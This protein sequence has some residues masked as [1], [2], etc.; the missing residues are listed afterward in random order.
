M[1]LLSA[2]V[3]VSLSIARSV[4][5]V[6]CCTINT[7]CASRFRYCC[8]VFALVVSSGVSFFSFLFIGARMG[9]EEMDGRQRAHQAA[10]D[11]CVNNYSLLSVPY[12]R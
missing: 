3:Q 5:I 6:V 11:C 4:G 12:C 7:L 9:E 1:S 8:F 10:S 2:G